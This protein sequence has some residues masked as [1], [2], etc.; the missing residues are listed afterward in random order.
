MNANERESI[1]PYWRPFAFIR[2]SPDFDALRM[3]EPGA[4]QS[5]GHLIMKHLRVVFLRAG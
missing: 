5:T 1:E 4:P 3:S 2:G